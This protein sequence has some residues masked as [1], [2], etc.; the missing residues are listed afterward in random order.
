MQLSEHF[1]MTEMLHSDTALKYGIKN[2]PET[3]EEA[4]EVKKNLV[5]L[6]NQI[7]EPLREYVQQPI[8]INSA[9][10]CKKLNKILHSSSPTSQHLSGAAVDLHVENTEH[11]LKM[12][13]FIMDETDFDQLIWERNKAGVQWLHVSHKRN[14]NNRHQVLNIKN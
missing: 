13:H 6:C 11:L 3:P 8:Y 5:A 7:L 10:R 2:E 1:S 12:M 9:Y 14:G 4:E